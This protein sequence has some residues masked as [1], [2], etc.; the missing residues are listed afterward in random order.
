LSFLPGNKGKGGGRSAKPASVFS[1]RKR[2]GE[3]GERGGRGSR[4]LYKVATEKSSP[5][6]KEGDDD[7][8]AR[9]G[10]RVITFG[11]ETQKTEERTVFTTMKRQG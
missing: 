4:G 3:N 10:E 7:T 8:V 6:T 1:R 5:F 11:R 9:S 2:E